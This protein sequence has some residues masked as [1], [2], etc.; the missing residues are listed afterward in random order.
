M[1]HSII[2]SVALLGCALL[3]H[4]LCFGQAGSGI[5]RLQKQ[6]TVTQLIVDGKPF[7]ALSGE[8]GNNT[9]T[10]LENMEPI[11]PRLL[12]GNLN[13]VLAAISWAQMEP[14][15]GKF[16]FTIIDGV[17]QGARRAQPQTGLPLVWKLEERPVELCPVLGKEGFRKVPAHPAPQRQE[18]G[19][20]E[21]LRRLP[22][23]MPTPARSGR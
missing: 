8:L 18:H 4:S 9:A 17:I 15:Q 21:H 7:L 10:S 20:A 12:S 14:E 5:P 19:T 23:A 6:G 1:K 16:D 22:R 13:C 3:F 11:W 2:R